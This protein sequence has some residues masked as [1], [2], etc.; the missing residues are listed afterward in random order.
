M[1]PWLHVPS[2]IQSE[3]L[4]AGWQAQQTELRKPSSKPRPLYQALSPFALSLAQVGNALPRP[5]GADSVGMLLR[6]LDV[7]VSWELPADEH[8]P[9]LGNPSPD[10]SYLAKM[11]YAVPGTGPGESAREVGRKRRRAEHAIATG[12]GSAGALRAIVGSRRD[13][14][15]FR[16]KPTATKGMVWV[17]AA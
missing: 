7:L 6:N 12:R 13:Q 4:V 14:L 11:G 8:G 5:L 3:T 1:C 9:G 17:S 2:P 10:H 16:W 15:D